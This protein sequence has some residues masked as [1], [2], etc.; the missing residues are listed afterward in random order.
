MT[1][2]PP[3]QP[4]KTH[5]AKTLWPS[6]PGTLKL[7][8]RYGD[9]L[10]CVRYRHDASGLTRYT[11]VELVIDRTLVTGRRIDRQL[12]WV[13]IPYTDRHLQSEARKYDARW[14]PATGRWLMPGAVVKVLGLESS[15][16]LHTQPNNPSRKPSARNHQAKK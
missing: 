1:T 15:A 10:L 9:A 12:F 4:K 8:R 7:L 14:D 3:R 16:V 6:Q 2:S 13:N 11:T 5:V